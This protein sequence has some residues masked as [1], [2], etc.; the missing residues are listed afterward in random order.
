MED[1]S[2]FVELIDS[3]RKSA[4]PHLQ[5]LRRLFGFENFRPGQREALALV[6]GRNG[7]LVAPTSFGKSICFQV[8][9]LMSRS[10][11]TVVISPLKALMRDQVRNLKAVGEKNGVN[12]P[13]AC[14]NSDN[15]SI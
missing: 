2:G 12:L 13:V 14:L 11:L 7:V 15:K 10:R 1:Y 9:A 8:P 4:D 6:T 3:C 5:L